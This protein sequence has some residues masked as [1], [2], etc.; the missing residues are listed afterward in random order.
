[1]TSDSVAVE[2]AAEA[3]RSRKPVIH[4]WQGAAPARL[5]SVRAL[6]TETRLRASGRVIAAA[7]PEAGTEAYSVSF[8][9]SFGATA[10]AADSAGRALL[11][12]TT[13]D[14]ERQ[15][16]LTRTEEGV[17]LVDRG[18]EAERADFEGAVSVDVVGAVTFAT[19][20]VRHLGL[21]TAAGEFEIPVVSVSLPDLAITVVHHA[22]RT[23][24]LDAEGATIDLTRGKTTS[25]VRVD[26]DGVVVDF[27]GIASR[28]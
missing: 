23:V 5:E 6:I 24:S 18:A 22:Y 8:D 13:A 4:T 14:H 2:R 7:D 27:P 17:W 21:H 11:R 19:L 12:T 10:D 15:L 9:A 28:L 1:M 25:R 3:A 16:A 20:P 26:A